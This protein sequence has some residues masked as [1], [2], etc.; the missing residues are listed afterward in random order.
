MDSVINNKDT[1]GMDKEDSSMDTDMVLESIMP[2]LP[3]LL[4]TEDQSP[5]PQTQSLGGQTLDPDRTQTLNQIPLNQSLGDLFLFYAPD[6]N[7]HDLYSLFDAPLNVSPYHPIQ[8][9]FVYKLV[10]SKMCVCLLNM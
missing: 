2:L 9:T 6:E 1:V 7:H 3:I 4:Q 5:I 10:P 8:W